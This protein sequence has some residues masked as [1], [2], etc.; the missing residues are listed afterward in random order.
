MHNKVL[1]EED[2]YHPQGPIYQSKIIDSFDELNDEE[3]AFEERQRLANLF[4]PRSSWFQKNSDNPKATKEA[5]RL[6]EESLVYSATLYHERAQ[7]FVAEKDV[8]S[9]RQ[10]YELALASYRKYI[11]EFPDREKTYEM[12]YFYAEILYALENYEA[13][14]Y[15]YLKVAKSKVKDPRY[16]LDSTF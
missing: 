14:S 12:R 11:W 16:K 2:P 10:S 9:A 4:G 13:A 1:L 6:I 8:E 3:K 7:K 15:H 5:T